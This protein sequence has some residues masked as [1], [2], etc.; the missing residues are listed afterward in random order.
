MTFHLFTSKNL[1]TNKRLI[2]LLFLMS[3]S[4][5]CKISK[6]LIVKTTINDIQRQPRHNPSRSRN[7]RSPPCESGHHLKLRSYS[8]SITAHALY[9]ILKFWVCLI[10]LIL[11][12]YH[13]LW[14]LCKNLPSITYYF[15]PNQTHGLPFL[16]CTGTNYF[17]LPLLLAK[18]A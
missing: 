5:C 15:V 3:M 14:F 4:L 17:A 13:Y 11:S 7:R 9:T 1:I 18:K 16:R 6:M 10:L 12:Y 8:L 2:L